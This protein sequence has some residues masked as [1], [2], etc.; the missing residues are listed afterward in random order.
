MYGLSHLPEHLS[1][2]E[3]ARVLGVSEKTV[4]RWIRDG[5]L[6][7]TRLATFH[8]HFRIPREAVLAQLVAE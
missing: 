2:P 7:A 5:K 4:R 8:G 3:T 6:P 1:L